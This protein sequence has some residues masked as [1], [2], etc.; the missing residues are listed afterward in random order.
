[1]IMS[2]TMCHGTR[3]VYDS[4]FLPGAWCLWGPRTP[5]W[6]AAASSGF[7]RPPRTCI[8]VS[9][10]GPRVC[11]GLEGVEGDVHD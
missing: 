1:M 11:G 6:T 7:D 4:D 2:S 8:R 9:E 3:W 10:S 5:D